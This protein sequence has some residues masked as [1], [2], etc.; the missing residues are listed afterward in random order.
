MYIWIGCRLPEGF[1][2]ALRARCVPLGQEL[3]LD[4]AGFSLPQ[5]IS[6]KISFEAGEHYAQILDFLERSLKKEKEFYVN[7]SGIER[8]GNILWLA[9]R[10]NGTLRRLHNMLDVELK[11]RFAISQHLFDKAFAF[12]STLFLGEPERLDMARLALADLQLP[13]VL[14]IDTFLLGVS[15]TGTS[16][17]YHVVRQIQV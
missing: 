8:M 15:E 3:G 11:S 5:H 17:S 12:H 13:E 1:E 10:E 2:N 16:G 9:F 6:L 7:L 4:L 14:P